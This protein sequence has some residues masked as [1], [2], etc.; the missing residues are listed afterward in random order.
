[1]A[2][3]G[4]GLVA[5]VAF[6]GASATQM[7]AVVPAPV[8]VL[9]LCA[10]LSRRAASNV[11]ATSEGSKLRNRAWCW[12]CSFHNFWSASIVAVTSTY[13]TAYHVGPQLRL[14]GSRKR[15][16]MTSWNNGREMPRRRE[17]GSVRRI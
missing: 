4:T 13:D 7:L 16:M 12:W 2:S 6:G 3:T 5:G 9:M 15:A 1:M 14:T 11:A 8:V 17:Y 10:R